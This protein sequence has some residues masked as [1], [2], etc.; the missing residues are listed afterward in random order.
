MGNTT[1]DYKKN[2]LEESGERDQA[3]RKK[4]F[5]FFHDNV[6]TLHILISREGRKMA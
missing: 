5:S 2:C 4:E 1:Q 3:W 6:C